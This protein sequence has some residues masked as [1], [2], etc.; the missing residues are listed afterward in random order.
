MSV[1]QLY[2]LNAIAIAVPRSVPCFIVICY[3]FHYIKSLNSLVII[4]TPIFTVHSRKHVGFIPIL[5]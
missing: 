3:L 5:I 2:L 4:I 1:V